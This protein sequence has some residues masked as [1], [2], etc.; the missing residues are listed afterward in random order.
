MTNAQAKRAKEIL[1]E[2]SELDHVRRQFLASSTGY[3]VLSDD[4]SNTIYQVYSN[5][6]DYTARYMNYIITGLAKDIEK[7]NDELKHL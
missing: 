6:E 1:D 7:L 4:R 3:M 2:I 5:K